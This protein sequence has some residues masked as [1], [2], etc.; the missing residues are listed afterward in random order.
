MLK[1]DIFS[2]K[3]TRFFQTG[4]YMDFFFKQVV[5]VLVRNVFI[6]SSQFFSEK[7]MIEYLT[8]KIID[9]SIFNINRL[10][11]IGELFYTYYFIQVLSILFYFI[12]L[13]N[14]YFI[15]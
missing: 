12:I 10:L 4:F 14:I 7:Y 2:F 9:S 6:Y 5:E 3:Y 11:G 15:F 1:W 13:I 8:K